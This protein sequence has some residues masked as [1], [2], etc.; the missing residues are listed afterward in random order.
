MKSEWIWFDLDDT[1]VD[2]HTNSRIALR[3]IHEECGLSR[4]YQ[5]AEEW[6]DTYE[7]HNKQLW[8]A[9]SRAEIT[10]SFLRLDRFASPLRPYWDGTEA[11]LEDFSRRLDPLYLTRLAEQTALVDGA[12]DLLSY[13]RARDYNIGVLSNGF[14]DIQHRKLTNTGLDRQ[15]DLMVLSDDIGVNK[16]DPRLYRHA[17]ERSGAPDPRSHTMIG[18]NL[19][20]DIAGAIASGW[21]AIHL[22]PA[23][24]CLSDTGG[25]TVTPRLSLLKDLF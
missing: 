11:Q 16:P 5:S 22:D 14:T 6:V 25:V 1:L 19:S 8:D 18:D 17:M 7:R 13:L 2:F 21:R 4:Y 10:Q 23:A 12:T 9:Y 24:P 3:L 15:V 20:T